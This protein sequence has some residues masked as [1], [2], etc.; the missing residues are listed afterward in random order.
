MARR[1][2]HKNEIDTNHMSNTKITQNLTLHVVAHDTSPSIHRNF[3]LFV[4]CPS[5]TAPIN[6]C[7]RR[8]EDLN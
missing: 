7:E 1:V 5:L 2:E 4:A 8:D 6:T 3:K